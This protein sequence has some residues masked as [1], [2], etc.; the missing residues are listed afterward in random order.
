MFVLNLNSL[1]TLLICNNLKNVVT[2]VN[3]VIGRIMRHLINLWLGQKSNF[4]I[5]P[6][7][8]NHA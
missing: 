3:H 1:E 4:T 2:S 8:D 7:P 6:I 5:V